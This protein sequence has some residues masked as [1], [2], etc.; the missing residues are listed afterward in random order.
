[1]AFYPNSAIVNP[2]TFL[3]GTYMGAFSSAAWTNKINEKLADA[4][5]YTIE[6]TNGYDSVSRNGNLN[7]KIKQISGAVLNDLVYQVAIAENEIQYNAPNGETHFNNTFRDFVTIPTG[8]PFTISPGQT[9]TY[10]HSYSIPAQINQD[11]TDLVVFVQRNNNTG[12]DVMGVEQIKI[13]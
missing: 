11:L 5:T 2:R 8:E 3:L 7:I 6:L 1:M 9:N 13:K 12:R 10:D 4:R